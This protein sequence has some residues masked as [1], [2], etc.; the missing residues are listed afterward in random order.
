MAILKKRKGRDLCVFKACI[1]NSCKPFVNYL[2]IMT[3]P[4]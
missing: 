3:L 1:K 4:G 2:W